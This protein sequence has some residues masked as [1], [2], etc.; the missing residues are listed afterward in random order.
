MNPNQVVDGLTELRSKLPPEVALWAGG[1]APVLHRRRVDGVRPIA[2]LEDV[3][4]EVE[5]WRASTS[6]A[7]A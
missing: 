1:S 6:A 7:R 2:A 5:R 4:P 3:L